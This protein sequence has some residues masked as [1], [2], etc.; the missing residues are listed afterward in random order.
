MAEQPAWMRRQM[1]QILELDMEELEVE[2]VDDSASS[3]SSDVSTFLRNTHGGGETGTSEEVTIN[4]SRASLHTYVGEVVDTRS[5]FAFL[6]GGEV[7]NLPM[8]YLQGFVLFP[9]ATLTLRVIQPRFLA[10]VDKAINHVDA[11]C[12]IGVVHVY[13]HINDGLHSVASIGTTAEIHQV[14]QSGDGTSNV[15]TRG[16]Q[17]FRLRRSW[18]DADEVPWG[19]VQII[20]EDTP[21][22]TP[23]NAFVQLAANTGMCYFSN[24]DED[25]MREL[26]WQ[27][28][29][30]INEFDASVNKTNMGDD[31]DLRF[32]ERQR[33]YR[34]ACNSKMALEAPLSF[35]PRWAYKMYDSYSLARRA[36]D[37]WRQIV[38]NPSMD[39]H[40]RKPDL[41]SFCI[42]S[43]LPISGSARQEL[44][45]IDGISYRL[46]REIQLLKAFNLMRCRNCLVL[47][48]RRSDMVVISNGCPVGA[49]VKPF[50]G[51]QEMITVYN[52]SGL[53][54]YGNPSEVHSWFPGYTWTIALC[55]ACES[56]IGWL[57][58]AAKKNLVPKS[59]WGIRSSQILD[60]TQSAQDRSSM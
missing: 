23:R 59:F 30:C 5:R 26:S 36:A 24:E 17:R 21:S 49:Y 14:R 38:A 39:D 1:E 28:H 8:L 4:T 50:D 58:S 45:E 47:I 18:I 11:P 32:A 42:G 9:E 19:E 53:A 10:T 51:A 46:Q 41:L 43:K 27:N 57:F 34:A 56:N 40:V 3:S 7:L 16:Q 48:A 60:D 22:R 44:L 20:E 54:L 55:A 15:S 13:R 37:L 31:D 33:Q 6:N 52:A 29:D 35:W 25:L 2:E 12:M